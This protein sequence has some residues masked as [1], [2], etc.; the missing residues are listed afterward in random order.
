MK[1]Q[2]VRLVKVALTVRYDV[3]YVAARVRTIAYEVPVRSTRS[4]SYP[5]RYVPEPPIERGGPLDGVHGQSLA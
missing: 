4:I 2:V 3:Q 1:V 5:T